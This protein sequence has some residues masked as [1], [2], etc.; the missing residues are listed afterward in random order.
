MK[1]QLRA[2]AEQG[3]AQ[4]GATGC[5]VIDVVFSHECPPLAVILV[6]C[7]GREPLQIIIEDVAFKEDLESFIFKK[8][9]EYLM[10]RV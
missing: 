1:T 5:E 2:I 3:L 10:A 6:P 9:K 8:L 4:L 7:K